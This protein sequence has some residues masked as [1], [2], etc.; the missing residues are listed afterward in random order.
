LKTIKLIVLSLLFLHILVY[1]RKEVYF[2]ILTEPVASSESKVQGSSLKAAVG[3][4]TIDT[5]LISNLSLFKTYNLP[6]K[7]EVS[8]GSMSVKAAVQTSNKTQKTYIYS[9]DLDPDNV[10]AVKQMFKELPSFQHFQPNYSYYPQLG[11]A[12]VPT[13][14]SAY[15]EQQQYMDYMKFPSVWN[16]STGNG[17]IVAVIDSGIHE[18][19]LEFCSSKVVV[20]CAS[21]DSNIVAPM[22]FP[23]KTKVLLENQYS[24]E[25]YDSGSYFDL[26]GHGTHVA[27]I[28]GAQL[29]EYEGSNGIVGAAY[30]VKL[31]PLK[32][33]YA[34]SAPSNSK[35][36]ETFA[37]SDSI[38]S[39]IDYA[40]A[41]NADIINMSLG[42]CSLYFEG[43]QVIK[44]AVNNAY[45]AKVFLVA[46]S[47]NKSDATGRKQ[48]NIYDARCAPAYYANTLAVNSVDY[49][50]NLENYSH[51]GGDI[52]AYGGNVERGVFS[53]TVE[54][55]YNN[56]YSSMQGTSQAAPFVSALA[57][58]IQSYY[59]QQHNGEKMSPSD[60]AELITKSAYRSSSYVSS[61]TGYGVID[62]EKAFFYLG[63]YNA[64]SPSF[65][66]TFEGSSGN[67]SEFLCYPNPLS[68]K[69]SKLTECSFFTLKTG[70]YDFLVY[71]R[72]GERVYSK[73][74][75][76]LLPGKN[77]IYWNGLNDYLQSLPNG[78][79][80]VFLHIKYEDTTIKPLLKKHFVTVFN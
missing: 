35:G 44:Y 13:Q 20:S 79:Y 4:S 50:D 32:V 30:G 49:E 17:V 45:T 56:Y 66:V 51:Y 52:S 40:V 67:H 58:L 31:M 76:A 21:G 65:S 14:S 55:A 23:S 59:M 42:V 11:E 5:T 57:A 80:Q 53:A 39:A 6:V 74:G 16:Y 3:A 48:V 70:T 43:D 68:F 61:S 71:S 8:T 63:A 10:G 69:E 15:Q 19:H 29:N 26:S 34:V 77:S 75:N 62:A 12:S 7:N 47:G 46:S 38:A 2:V 9:F 27:G 1:A 24:E 37:K 36:F 41:N 64:D 73:K 78:V 60:L 25:E 72:R 33:I 54:G 28:I 18:T 22:G